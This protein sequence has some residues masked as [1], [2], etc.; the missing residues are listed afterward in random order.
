MGESALMA[1][2][3]DSDLETVLRQKLDVGLYRTTDEALRK[4][5][6]LLDEP[7][8]LLRLRALLAVGD[9]QAG[10]GRLIEYTP[11]LL[12]EISREAEESSADAIDTTEP[13]ISRGG[14][15]CPPC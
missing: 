6:R 8:R 15:P 11:E 14:P 5:E 12:E 7:Y 1:I 4:A 2:R 3:H 13:R 9:E 10:R